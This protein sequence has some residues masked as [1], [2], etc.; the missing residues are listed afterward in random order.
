MA[1]NTILG[2]FCP[3]GRLG[4]NSSVGLFIFTFNCQEYI[5]SKTAYF[6]IISL[7]FNIKKVYKIDQFLANNYKKYTNRQIFSKQIDPFD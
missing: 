6:L 2:H 3:N 5:L 1:K 7:F 4:V